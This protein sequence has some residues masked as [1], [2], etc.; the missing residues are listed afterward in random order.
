[1]T[2]KEKMKNGQTYLGTEEELVRERDS[3]K[4]L[5]FEFN[6][7]KPSFRKERQDI[8]N[9]LFGKVGE[10]AWIESPFNC[11]YGYNIS[12]GNNF[13]ANHNC[14]ILDPA[15][16]TIGNNVL[17]GPNVG[18][19]T[20]GHPFN[21][22]ERIK[23]HEYAKP[24]TIGDNVWI[25]ADVSIIGGVTIGENTVIGAGSVVTKDIPSGVLAVRKSCKSY[26][27]N[28]VD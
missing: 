3:A 1:M 13:Y 20:P 7:I 4:D 18:I 15:S 21:V 9:K 10:N 11:D 19:Y 5:C 24:V 16:V 2:E 27:R 6:N 12:V 17:L 28:C 23:G 8:I 25:G 14:I 22:E 26:K